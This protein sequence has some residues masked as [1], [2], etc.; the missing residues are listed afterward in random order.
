MASKLKKCPFCG[1]EAEV[2]LG[3]DWYV[4]CTHCCASVSH[5]V[6]EADAIAVWN[7]RAEPTFTREELD[8]IRRG[9]AEIFGN[10]EKCLKNFKI[11]KS[12]IIRSILVKCAAAQ[13]GGEK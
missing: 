12:R 13:K 1:G 6:S 11:G 8:M 10:S 5:Y 7:R 4:E 9:A 2:Y 3:D